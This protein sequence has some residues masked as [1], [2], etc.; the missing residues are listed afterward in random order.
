M[1][2]EV[3]RIVVAGDVSI[4]WLQMSVSAASSMSADDELLNWQLHPG[5]RMVAR[6]GG[7]LLLARMVGQATGTPVATH[8]V[9]DLENVPTDDVIHS[10]V[11]VG[12]FPY[13]CNTKDKKNLVYR[14]QKFLGFAGPASGRPKLTP[15]EQD[16][17]DAD[18]VIVDDAGNGFRDE[19]RVWPASLQTEDKQPI[20]IFKMSRPVAT[21][22]LWDAV[23]KTHAD[24]MLVV[25]SADDLRTEGV[26]ISRRLSWE[27]TAKDFVWQLASNPRLSALANC[28]DLV[29]RFGIDGA[30]HYRRRGHQAETRLY[31]DPAL[32]E[33]GF[34][35]DC[36]GSMLGFNSAFVA[37]LTA[38]I[39][40]NGLDGVGEGVQDG[41]R[42]SRRLFREGFGRDANQ[43]DYAGA[44]IFAPSSEKDSPIAHVRIPEP[45][46]PEPADPNFWC[47]LK[48]LRGA[49][50]E[51]VAH[52]V[53][54]RGDAAVLQGVP[55]GRFGRLV[56]VDRAEI[57]SYRSIKNLMHEYLAQNKPK[58][59]L[60]IAVF[61]SP[62]SGKSFGVTEVAESIAP[63]QVEKLTFNVSQFG[64][65]ADLVKAL[66]KVRDSV[67]GG[68]IPL[69]FFDEFDSTFGTRLGWLKYF[70]APMQDGEFKDGESLHPIGKA[71]FVFAG[72]TCS[73]YQEFCGTERDESDTA[74]LLKQLKEAKGPDFI[75]RLRGYVNVLGPNPVNEADSFFIIRRAVLL[76]T[77][78]TIKTKHLIDRAGHARI[79]SGVLRAMIKVP[80]YK[81]G[82]RSMD[83]VLDMSMLAGRKSF[84]QAALP[85]TEQLQLH[86]DAE[87][88]ARLVVRDVLLGS[89]R[90][91]LAKAI[92][93][94]Y[95]EDQKDIKSPDD[96]AMQPWDQLAEHLKESNRKQADQIPEKL[97]RVGYGFIPVVD[98]EPVLVKFT[99]AEVESLAEMEH[100]RWVASKR[101]DGWTLGPRDHDRK[102]SP[103]LV[104]WEDLKDMKD[105]PQQWDRD[106]VEGIPALMARAGF[107]LYRLDT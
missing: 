20:I 42:S 66:H 13:S 34:Q 67:L 53:V 74:D 6:P 94:K 55:V 35:D 71:I 78:L 79:D 95:R 32:A 49:Q 17:P 89:A 43:L 27:R 48:E 60:S 40:K 101:L 77:L 93:E 22:K 29:V 105:N 57:E 81:H 15:V 87:M 69:V 85:S 96:T 16:D 91:I 86:V 68:Q 72:G 33:D 84:E 8:R 80:V 3:C 97:R 30:I 28:T 88:F 24:R 7:A 14:V 52:D 103:Y 23:R 64:A 83:A 82:V 38:Q 65:P 90:E 10:M 12:L 61:G 59:P 31:Y 44:H 46:A 47:I 37:A 36:P 39:A 45:T 41:T 73:T 50:L 63:G 70:L 26:Q 18:I 2:S 107:E 106:A 58:R 62:G 1:T 99:P 9:G 25:V 21:G 92:H 5:T 19:P 104:S 51:D 54:L 100:D 102:T 76:R 4:D 56:T 11:E 75:S 98:R